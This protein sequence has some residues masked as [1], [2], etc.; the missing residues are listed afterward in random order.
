MPL[1]RFTG[2]RF[3]LTGVEQGPAHLAGFHWD[4]SKQIAWTGLNC[5]AEKFRQHADYS[6]SRKFQ[7]EAARRQQDIQEWPTRHRGWLERFLEITERKVSLLDDYGDENWDALPQEIERLLLKTAK[8]DNDNIEPIKKFVFKGLS[9]D[10]IMREMDGQ[11]T[12]R[13]FE[14]LSKGFNLDVRDVLI[15][16]YTFL[17]SD[18]E[19]RF[20]AY[21]AGEK[22]KRL[23]EDLDTLTGLE[24]ETYL[25]KLLKEHG[26]EDVRTT[27]ATGDQGADLIAHL[28]GRTI[29]IQAK[30]YR[31]SVGNR[32]VQE[33]AG[34]VRYYRDNER[35]VHT[36]GQRIGASKQ[37]E[38]GRWL[39]S[40][41]PSLPVGLMN[42]RAA[43]LRKSLCLVESLSIAILCL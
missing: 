32:A 39:R 3:E 42:Y 24:F 33:V 2:F 10:E 34:A 41:S 14:L 9:S 17:R 18:L 12:A 5:V 20:R 21:H 13:R 8:A 4:V 22:D 36:V 35:Y 38:I 31:G 26:F 37:C 19:A 43:R 16:K 29:V 1:L 28:N 30:R 7:E 40:A 25:M 15:K 27:P 11:A 6:A 23:A